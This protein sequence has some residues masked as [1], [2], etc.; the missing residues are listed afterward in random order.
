MAIY[1]SQQLDLLALRQQSP[2]FRLPDC[3]QLAV[4]L[5]NRSLLRIRYSRAF[6][7]FEID[8]DPLSVNGELYTHSLFKWGRYSATTSAQVS[9]KLEFVTQS[10]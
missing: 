8:I 7:E 2:H 5:I 10:A 6:S 9:S 3:R 1:T 4:I